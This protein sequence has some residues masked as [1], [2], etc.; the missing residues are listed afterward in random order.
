MKLGKI[1]VEGPLILAPMAGVTDWAFRTVCAQLG[2]DI[3]VTEMVSSRALVYRDQKSARLLRKNEGS[4]CGAQIFGNDPA[5][6]AEGARLALEISGCDFLDINMGCPMPKIANSGDGCGLMRTPE[7]A[8]E[9]VRQVVKAVEVP[10]TVKCRLGWDKGNINV[11]DFTKRMEQAGAAMISVHGRTRSMLYTG[12]ADWD[13]IRKVKEQLSIPVI[14]N[15]D[16]TGGEAAVRCAKWTGADGLMIG[17]ST[18]GDPWIFAEIKAAMRGEE[19]PGRPVLADRI[20][21]A[22]RQFELAEQD[23]GEHIACLEARKHFAWYL[24]GVRNSSFY[25]KEIS[26]MSKM[27]DIYRIAREIS[28]DLK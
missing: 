6:M 15:G 2:A 28:R 24:R 7:L 12:V 18:F 8:E 23:H 13:T 17:R 5:T 27:E 21:V 9:I 10:V 26:S 19:Y 22:V 1:E 3:T 14:A 20:A 16:I 25:K 11:L 4:I